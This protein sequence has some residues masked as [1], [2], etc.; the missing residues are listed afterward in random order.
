MG[1]T[2]FPLIGI[3]NNEEVELHGDSTSTQSLSGKDKVFGTKCACRI[4]YK[5]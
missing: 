4:R 3:A 5:G 1:V 2:I